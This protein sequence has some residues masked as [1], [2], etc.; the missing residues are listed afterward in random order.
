M[1]HRRAPRLRWTGLLALIAANCTPVPHREDRG[2]LTGE[3]FY[4][5]AVSAERGCEGE[6]L[7]RQQHRALGVAARGEMQTT[8][9]ASAGVVLRL[10]RATLE[11]YDGEEALVDGP[12]SYGLGALGF[13]AGKDWAYVGASGGL[14]VAAL[15]DA[16]DAVVLT[17]AQVRL[18]RLDAVWMEATAGTYDP[19]FYVNWLG[20][21]AGIRRGDTLR[22]RVGL[23]AHAK[24]SRDVL[25]S[26]ADT[27]GG[28]PPL[29]TDG[30]APLVLGIDGGGWFDTVERGAYI[31][32][33]VLASEAGWGV[34][35]GTL[36]A[37]EPSFRLGLSYGFDGP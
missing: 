7:E 35:L 21:G 17:Y 28:Q 36:I 6:V 25:D 12:R 31:D 8:G 30:I 1:L 37:A 11:A 15:L 22:L 33:R 34:D 23:T 27:E 16:E 2:V 14:S 19:L 10:A 18:G 4:S 32:L 29:E 20:W 24:V 3:L 5:D 13:H 26:P 9:G